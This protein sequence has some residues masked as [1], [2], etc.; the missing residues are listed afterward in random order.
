MKAYRQ[1]IVLDLV[2]R[3]AITSQ[4]QLRRRLHARG[5]TI[6]QA[7]LSRDIKELGLVKRAADGA[8]SRPGPGGGAAA[9]V[10]ETQLRRTIL[11]YLRR[12]ARVQQLLVLRTDP[13][14]AQLLGI[15]VDRALIPEVVGTIAG[16][17]TV[18]VVCPD[19]RRARALARRLE[20]WA[21][22]RR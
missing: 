10:H 16:D 19:G 3:E 5:V 14:Q 17:D 7:T 4:E 1:S 9:R 21:K 15:A 13:G 12:V 6:T 11:E 20:G 22:A 2:D 18:L 8:Y